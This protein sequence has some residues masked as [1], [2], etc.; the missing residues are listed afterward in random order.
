MMHYCEISSPVGRLLLTGGEEGLRGISFQNGSHALEPKNDA[1]VMD[2]ILADD[3][4]LVTGKGKIYTKADL[5]ADARSGKTVYEHQDDSSQK[6]RVWGDTVVVTA[7]LR[8]PGQGHHGGK[9]FRVQALVQRHL[10]PD[11]VRLALRLRPGLESAS[12]RE[13]THGP[14]LLADCLSRPS[15]RIRVH[16]PGADG[17]A[18]RFPPVRNRRSAKKKELRE[19][20]R[21]GA[22]SPA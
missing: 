16:W 21:P 4:I 6:V 5:L 18:L 19:A 20:P 12:R 15:P 13:L 17:S 3:F 7:L 8:A 14:R 9:A 10:R 22:R 1:A 11:A 2:R